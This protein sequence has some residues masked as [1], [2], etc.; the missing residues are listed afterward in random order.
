MIDPPMH[1]VRTVEPAKV[2]SA[3]KSSGT[4]GKK[5]L[6]HLLLVFLILYDSNLYL[7]GEWL[8]AQLREQQ[9]K[10]R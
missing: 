7:P 4:L 9:G 2:L 3:D 5:L 8:I 10:E 1:L 6:H